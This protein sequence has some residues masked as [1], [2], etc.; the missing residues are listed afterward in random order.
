MVKFFRANFE[1]EKSGEVGNKLIKVMFF[2]DEY[3]CAGYNR[4][5]IL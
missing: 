2:T 1:G 4:M 3:H 5:W